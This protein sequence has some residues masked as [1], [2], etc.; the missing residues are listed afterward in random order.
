MKCKI[1]VTFLRVPHFLLPVEG[2]LM[3]RSSFV[4]ERLGVLSFSY[5]RKFMGMSALQFLS[6]EEETSI[7]GRKA[8]HKWATRSNKALAVGTIVV[9]V[10][11]S[12]NP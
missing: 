7:L 10:Q 12:T 11:G 5:S 2:V 6:L 9:L 1:L 8:G 3:A 4:E